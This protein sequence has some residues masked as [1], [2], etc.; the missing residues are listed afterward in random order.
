MFVETLAKN[1]NES[2]IIQVLDILIIWFVVYKLIMYARGTQM[3]NLLKGVFVFILTKSLT[4]FLGLQT[5]DWLLDQILNSAVVAL[6][7]L[8]QPELRRALQVIGQNIFRNRRS[9]KNPSVRLIEDLEYALK[10]MSRRKI[11][12]LIAIEQSDELAEYIET[13][14][15]L[16]S[17]ITNQLL[18]N[19]FVPNT[20]LHD[21]AVVIKNY[22]IAAASCFLPLSENDQISKD[23]GTRHRAAIGLSE[24]T[25][26]LTLIVS[27]ET[28]GISITHNNTLYRE[29]SNQELK[30]KLEEYLMVDEEDQD[31]DVFR[32][33][34]DY[35][36]DTFTSRG[37]E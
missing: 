18:I 31:K 23:L 19:I 6:I 2:L 29:L 1:L 20:P 35:L 11:G 8:F 26:A 14:I 32:M 13:G 27:E 24:V 9:H 16:D 7:V 17:K 15:A 28:G 22:R 25:D 37:D 4:S 34:K 5:L 3:M 12:A 10:Y 30:E 36:V 33:V 21:G